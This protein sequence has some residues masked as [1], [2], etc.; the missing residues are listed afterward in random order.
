MEIVVHVAFSCD[1][2]CIVCLTCGNAVAVEVREER[3]RC[4]VSCTEDD[5]VYI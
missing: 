3:I 4:D 2:G 5:R 1:K